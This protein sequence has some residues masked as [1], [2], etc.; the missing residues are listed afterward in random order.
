MKSTHE[1][2]KDPDFGP[3]EDD[4]YGAKSLYGD[5]PPAPAGTN[6]YPSP[7]SLRWDRPHYAD[8]VFGADG[9][10]V[11]VEEEEEEEEEDEFSSSMKTEE[12]SLI[13]LFM[14][15]QINLS[16]PLSGF[17]YCWRVV[18]RWIIIW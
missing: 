15:L 9:K 2:F 13:C 10:E 4:E 3:S 14:F 12:V 1:K 7:E 8:K 5:G 16:L 6:K 11:E 17:L 18:Y